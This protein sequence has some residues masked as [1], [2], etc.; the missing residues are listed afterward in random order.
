MSLESVFAVISSMILLPEV[1][2]PTARE[3][4]GM[5]LIFAAIIVSQIPMQYGKKKTNKE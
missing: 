2:A 1:P 3:W 4:I 5:V